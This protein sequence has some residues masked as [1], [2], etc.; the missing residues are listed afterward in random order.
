M[1]M[2][3]VLFIGAKIRIRY[4]GVVRQIWSIA[5]RT[6]TLVLDNSF[7]LFTYY[8]HSFILVTENGPSTR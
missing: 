2:S 1:S 5:S 7:E 8:G 6:T 3:H 4:D